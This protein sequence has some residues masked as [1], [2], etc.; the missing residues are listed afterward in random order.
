[1]I[2]IVFTKAAQKS[3][4]KAPP[5]VQQKLKVFVALVKRNG[6]SDKM[7]WQGFSPEMLQG[8]RWGQYS[9][10]L[11]RQWRAILT[12]T[13]ETLTLTIVEITPHDYRVR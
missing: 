4:R 1:M 3:F 10:R 7:D 13:H 11:N 5:Q 9:I 6:F 2:T 12:E 8:E